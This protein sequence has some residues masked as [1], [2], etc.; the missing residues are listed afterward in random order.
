[1]FEWIRIDGRER[2]LE[3]SVS[4]GCKRA[5]QKSVGF[6][7]ILVASERYNIFMITAL[8]A[9]RGFR[10]ITLSSVNFENRMV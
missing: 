10:K 4:L 7:P 6:S 5:I 9:L 8:R 2:P 3:E 1:V